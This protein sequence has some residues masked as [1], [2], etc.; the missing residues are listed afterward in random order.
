MGHKSREKWERRRRR[1]L[2]LPPETAAITQTPPV[3]EP[4]IVHLP[5]YDVTFGTVEHEETAFP[6]AIAAE[7]E[8]LFHLFHEHPE[9]AIPRLE[10]LLRQ[11]PDAPK[12][13]NFLICAHQLAGHEEPFAR[14]TEE[15]YRRFPRLPVRAESDTPG[16]ASIAD[17]RSRCRRSSTTPRICTTCI[18]IAGCST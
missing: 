6:K 13:Y 3:D 9:Q 15:L 17:I 11:F 1:E 16:S 2:G 8:K 5:G 18:R 4:E 7:E 12:L 14:L 10:E